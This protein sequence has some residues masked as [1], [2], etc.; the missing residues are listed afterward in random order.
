[1]LRANTLQEAKYKGLEYGANDYIMK[2][3]DI[4]KL[5]FN[6]QNLIKIYPIHIV[7]VLCRKN[8]EDWVY[9]AGYFNCLP[10]LKY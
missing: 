4:K 9:F 3:F 8:I 7:N 2:P 10:R 1:M 5:L 6:V